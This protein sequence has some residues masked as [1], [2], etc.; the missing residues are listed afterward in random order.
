MCLEGAKSVAKNNEV[1]SLERAGPQH[2]KDVHDAVPLVLPTVPDIV[3]DPRMVIGESTLGDHGDS[4][5]VDAFR[6][7]RVAVQ[8]AETASREAARKLATNRADQVAAKVAQRGA[9]PQAVGEMA[10]PANGDMAKPTAGH[11]DPPGVTAADRLC[12]ASGYG[13]TSEKRRKCSTG[14][15][16]A[17]GDRR[18]SSASGYQ[19]TPDYSWD[20]GSRRPLR[21]G[22]KGWRPSSSRCW[23]RF[24]RWKL[25]WRPECQ[26]SKIST[27]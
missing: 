16:V 4:V 5:C 24:Q 17:A 7:Q 14:Y 1:L 27:A 15:G 19:D 18:G 11:V 21:R 9:I 3:S 26:T 13:V 23:E 12:N 10:K 22:S 2:A 6:E 20:D 25:G 8:S